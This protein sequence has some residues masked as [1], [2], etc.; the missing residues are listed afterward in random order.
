MPCYNKAFISYA[1]KNRAG[2]A[3]GTPYYNKAF[4]SYADKN[5]AGYTIGAPSYNKDKRID[6]SDHIALNAKLKQA[7]RWADHHHMY[8][9]ATTKS[10]LI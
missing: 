4:I 2:Y 7:F 5:R 8:V 9:A 3:I 1:D 10:G 6:V